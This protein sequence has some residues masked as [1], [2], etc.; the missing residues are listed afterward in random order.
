MESKDIRDRIFEYADLFASEYGW[1]LEYSISLSQDIVLKLMEKI[2]KRQKSNYSIQTRLMAIAVNCGFS[3]KMKALDKL[4]D[5]NDDNEKHE[6]I[7]EVEYF[8]NVR[9]IMK[10][11]G[12]SNAEIEKQIKSGNITI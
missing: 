10:G 1:S 2:I 9:A 4:F 11:L 6:E 12:K 3:G 8:S 7:S 5:Q